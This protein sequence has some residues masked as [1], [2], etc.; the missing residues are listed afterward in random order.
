[1]VGVPPREPIPVQ[2]L[3]QAVDL[4]RDFVALVRGPLLD[5]ALCVPR[6]LLLV[7]R[8]SFGRDAADQLLRQ[9]CAQRISAPHVHAH[10][11]RTAG[12]RVRVGRASIPCGPR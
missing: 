3:K 6:G 12:D 4:Q 7:G 11:Y 8:Q 2:L 9:S 1:M 10:D 5:L